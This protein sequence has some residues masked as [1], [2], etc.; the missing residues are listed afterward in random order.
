MHAFARACALLSL[1]ALPLFADSLTK[2]YTVDF[3]RDVSS[4]DLKGFATRSDGRL[5]AGPVLTDLQGGLGA[6]L[7]WSL[8]PSAD[9][10]TWYVGTGPSGKIMEVTVDPT[11]GTLASKPW[12][13]VDDAQV[14]AL[15]RLADGRLVA[16]GSPKGSLTLLSD[17]KPVA[18]IFL[19]ST[20]VFDLLVLPPAKPGESGDLLV[21]AG[22][23]GRIY[24]VDLARF[25]KSGRAKEGVATDAA[26]SAAGISTFG[27]IRDRNV[28]TLA[29]LPD[30]RVL[31]GSAPDGNVYEFPASGGAP[32]MLMENRDAE[33]T[34]F[35]VN[36]D[37]SFYASMVAT[38]AQGETRIQQGARVQPQTAQPAQPAPIAPPAPGGVV[39]IA[40]PAQPAPALPG[41]VPA[42]RF[43]G[44]AFIV[45]FSTIG[46]PEIVVNRTNQ[47]FYRLA[48][49]GR[50]LLIT[51]GEQGDLFGYDP[52]DRLSLTYAGSVSAQVNGVAPWPGAASRFLLLRNNPAGLSLL[53]FDARAPRSAETRKLDIGL[54]SEFGAVRT[55]RIHGAPASEF[56]I[57]AKTSN[58]G[59]ELEGWTPWTRLAS[60][61][62]GAISNVGWKSTGPLR[63][64][65]AK[66]RVS[67]PA[68]ASASSAIDKL[69]WFYL[70]QDRRPVLTEFRILDPDYAIQPA[71]EPQPSPV[72]SLSQMLSQPEGGKKHPNFMNSQVYPSPGYQVF[73]WTVS[74]PDGDNL[75]SSLYLRHQGDKNWIPAVVDT[76]D[77]Y[78]QVDISHMPEGVY[79]TRLVVK[80]TA[81]RPPADRLTTTFETDVFVVD[82]TP[83]AIL[84]ASAKVVG[85]RLVVTVHGR[86]NLSILA[87]LELDFNQGDHEVSEQPVDGIR[88]EREET[89]SIDVPLSRVSGAT[90]VVASLYD[91]VG[92]R[93]T[94]VLTW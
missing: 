4:R 19:P 91:A 81:P 13:S 24:R 53:D 12:G 39:P 65:Y 62:Q 67:L 33:V 60:L 76:T 9:A 89:F 3:F 90:R 14:F 57:E 82:R 6:D 79:Y 87:G 22:N 63:G 42:P 80:E 35:S 55:A 36:P 46:F 15:A 43:A 41:L 18:R 8:A 58:G 30:G 61:D 48:R 51:G 92:N 7:V 94:R 49:V 2:T 77:S 68:G 28:R 32:L 85:D 54:L 5:V 74:D 31:A 86:D 11:K 75:V 59:D 69:Q 40:A 29:L 93:S 25:A 45:S 83:P 47:S 23:P 66:L 56:D 1:A 20:S 88:D 34:D 73:L 38:S 37:G 26:L 52:V 72:S 70:P 21:A 27:S 64:R 50:D 17:G 84:D 71:A 78:A 16:G 10:G 44:R